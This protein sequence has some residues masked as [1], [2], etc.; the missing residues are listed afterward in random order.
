MAGD[1]ASVG[2]PNDVP[3]VGHTCTVARDSEEGG[4]ALASTASTRFL[5]SSWTP[6]ADAEIK[7]PSGGSRQGY[8]S[9]GFLF[10]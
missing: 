3:Q 1:E 10:F 6:A 7:N 4:S 5:S 8:Q 9:Q 2:E